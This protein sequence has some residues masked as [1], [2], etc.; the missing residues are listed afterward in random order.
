[1]QQHSEVQSLL[2]YSTASSCVETE[3]GVLLVAASHS[4]T[5]W[6]AQ[7]ESADFLGGLFHQHSQSVI[8]EVS[9]AEVNGLQAIINDILAKLELDPSAMT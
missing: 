1:M 4:I 8:P 6:P 5:L 7:Y 3:Y 2:E 9:T